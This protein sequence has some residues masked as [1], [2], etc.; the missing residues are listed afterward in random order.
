MEKRGNKT[1]MLAEGGVMIAMSALLSYIRLY[2]APNGGSVSAG[3]MIPLLLFAIRWGILPGIAVG[4]GYGV[5][6]FILK[7]YFVHPLQFLL[8]YP[9][10]YGALG[11]A[12]IVF[13]VSKRNSRNS[14]VALSFGVLLGILGRMI[15]HVLSGVVFFSQYAGDQNPWVYSIVYNATYLIPELIISILVLAVIWKPLQNVFK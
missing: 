8:D 6:D 2:Q 9:I 14:Y 4:A 13:L 1:L 3:S 5:L 10:A 15:S 7:P 12:G 11:L